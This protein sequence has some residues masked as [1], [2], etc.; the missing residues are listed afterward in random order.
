MD[1][2][3]PTLMREILRIGH[4]WML[5]AAIVF[6]ALGGGIVVYLGGSLRWMF[7]SSASWRCSPCC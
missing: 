5:L 2:E 1:A 7:T 3:K 4:P 6:Y